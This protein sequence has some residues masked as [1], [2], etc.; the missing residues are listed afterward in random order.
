MSHYA[1]N[2]LQDDW[3]AHAR[4]DAE[5][6]VQAA[7][8]AA[9][10]YFDRATRRDRATFD[11]A[12]QALFGVTGPRANRDRDRARR[13]W[14]EATAEADALF[15]ATVACLLAHGEVS[16]EFD[17]KWTALIARSRHA[18]AGATQE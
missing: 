14:R 3:A 11:A 8:K 1:R 15:E 6:A 9:G 18:T 13:R 4:D 12:M 5:Q 2:H 10:W 7:E 16:A 17:E